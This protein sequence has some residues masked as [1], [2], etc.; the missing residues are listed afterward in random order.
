[1]NLTALFSSA[2][3]A[4][5]LLA[6]AFLASCSGL[7]DHVHDG[8]LPD[9][10]A[11]M[12]AVPQRSD[13]PGLKDPGVESVAVIPFRGRELHD[14]SRR[15]LYPVLE[16]LKA[17]PAQHLVIGGFSAR[18]PSEEYARQLAEARARLVRQWFADEDI[19]PDRLHTAAYGQETGS[20][21]V[22][23][24]VFTPAP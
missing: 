23:L 9:D 5:A 17:N 7:P 21:S 18:Q 2:A 14:D 16:R 8:S 24:G 6:A 20:N 22:E 10:E 3:P 19:A 13:Q 11:D 4:G 1:M 15:R 12:S